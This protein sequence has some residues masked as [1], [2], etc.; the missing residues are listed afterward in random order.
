MTTFQGSGQAKNAVDLQAKC[1]VQSGA[2]NLK[3]TLGL[4]SLLFQ[5]GHAG[6]PFLVGAATLFFATA[7]A[8]VYHR[9]F[10]SLFT[11]KGAREA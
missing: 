2:G 1:G 10:A 9:R 6:L 5:F 7:V 4:Q 8:F 11:R 3:L